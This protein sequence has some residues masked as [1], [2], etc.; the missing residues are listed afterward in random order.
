MLWAGV[1]HG[2][3]LFALHKAIG[4]ALTE[5]IGFQPEDRPYSP[6]VTLARLNEPGAPGAVDHYLEKNMGF[7][8]SSV[9]LRQFVLYSSVFIDGVPQYREEATYSLL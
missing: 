4:I 3:P 5:A 8:V 9:A 2:L 7:Q 1:E 6:H